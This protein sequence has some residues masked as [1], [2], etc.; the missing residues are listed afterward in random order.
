MMLKAV[1]Y[2]LVF[3]SLASGCL[4]KDSVD[5]CNYDPCSL[6][7]PAAEI[8]AVKDY[9]AANNLTAAAQQ[10]CSGVFYIIDAPGTGA[11]PGICSMVSATYIGK[12]TNGNE[13]ERGSFQRPIQLGGLIRGWANTLPLIKQGGKIRLFI[14]PTLGYGSQAVGSIPA[15]SI[16]IFDIDL[17]SVQ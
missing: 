1:I 13:F 2:A 16:L 6:V 8:Q 10:H 3:V 5:P 4:K 17:T 11:A 9:L 7:A 14:P 12:L 15:N